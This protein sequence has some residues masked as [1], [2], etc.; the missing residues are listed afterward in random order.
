MDIIWMVT[1]RGNQHIADTISRSD[2]TNEDMQEV[3][4]MLFFKKSSCGSSSDSEDWLD[5]C[6]PNDNE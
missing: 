6:I 4:G 5:Y 1:Q 3:A 2:S